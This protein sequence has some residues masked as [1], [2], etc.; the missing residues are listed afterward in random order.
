LEAIAAQDGPALRGQKWHR[1]LCAALGAG[2]AGFWAGA[3]RTGG[4]LGFA[5]LAALGIVPELLLVEE[6][7][8]AG[9]KD[10]ITATVD[11]FQ[12]LVNKLHLRVPSRGSSPGC[13]TNV[14]LTFHFQEP[15]PGSRYIGRDSLWLC[16]AGCVSQYCVW[17]GKPEEHRAHIQEIRSEKASRKASDA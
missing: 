9:G 3:G 14:P 16:V 6:Q 5:G 13:E 7:L 10:E 1:R 11:T 8:L 15:V 2:R 17:K 12:D 4:S